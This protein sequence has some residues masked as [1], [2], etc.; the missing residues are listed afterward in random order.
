MW[1]RLTGIPSISI[2]FKGRSVL[3]DVY[4]THIFTII[5]VNT[6][7]GSKGDF[8]ASCAVTSLKI[9][10]NYIVANLTVAVLSADNCSASSMKLWVPKKV[11]LFIVYLSIILTLFI[12]STLFNKDYTRI[13]HTYIYIYIYICIYM[14]IY[15]Y[16]YI[17]IYNYMCIYLSIY[18]S[19]YISIYICIYVHI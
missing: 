2:S 1:S 4:S 16:I 17:Y 3:C 19:I 13:L 5:H 6:L 12:L 8:P 10:S 9:K 14:Y 18:L 11:V 15:I 7:H